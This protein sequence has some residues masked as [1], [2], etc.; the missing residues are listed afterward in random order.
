MF[1][2]QYAKLLKQTQKDFQKLVVKVIGGERVEDQMGMHY[3]NNYTLFISMIG[4][5]FEQGAEASFCQQ[6]ARDARRVR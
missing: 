3:E 5:R 6:R 2:T 1:H 4:Q